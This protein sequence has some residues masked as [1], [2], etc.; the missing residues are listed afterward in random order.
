MVVSAFVV[1]DNCSLFKGD[2]HCTMK[3]V[4][5]LWFMNLHRTLTEDDASLAFF[6]PFP[7]WT[8]LKKVT[9]IIMTISDWPKSAHESSENDWFPCTAMVFKIQK[10][11]NEKLN[12]LLA[13][14]FRIMSIDHIVF[15]QT[16][17]LKNKMKLKWWVSIVQDI[18]YALS[19]PFNSSLNCWEH[20]AK[21]AAPL[22][23]SPIIHTWWAANSPFT[24]LKWM[25]IEAL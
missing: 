3:L 7:R 15:F 11:W 17:H 6:S 1:Y 23:V 21:E 20:W 2:F 19:L 4:V 13:V 12:V 18:Y 24:G 10:V 25:D 22:N 9:G 5:H 14:Q 8:S 16:L